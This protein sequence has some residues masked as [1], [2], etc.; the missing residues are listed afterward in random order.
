MSSN[1]VAW[2][3]I[4]INISS[5]Q[6]RTRRDKSAR[7]LEALVPTGFVDIAPYPSI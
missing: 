1:G 6:S 3:N 2:G 4:N 5:F 7:L